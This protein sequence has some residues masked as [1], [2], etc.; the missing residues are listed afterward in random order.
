VL[1]FFLSLDI[2]CKQ[3]NENKQKFK[4]FEVVQAAGSGGEM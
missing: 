1:K 3:R 4:Y 2:G